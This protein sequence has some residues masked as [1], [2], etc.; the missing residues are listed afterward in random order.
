[1]L[2]PELACR[3]ERAARGIAALT[4]PADP[5]YA[6]PL[7][8]AG[9]RI[10]SAQRREGT[11]LSA[12]LA[13]AFNASERYWVLPGVHVP[14]SGAARMLA[15]A[16][17]DAWPQEMDRTPAGPGVRVD[18][19]V[20]DTTTGCAY[21]IELKRGV[22]PIGADH[23]R[24]LACSLRALELVGRATA[25]HHLGCR[26]RAIR[27]LVLS[28]YGATG[29]PWHRTLTGGDMDRFF[30]LDLSAWVESHLRFF[31]F[32]VERPVPGLTGY[33][34]NALGASGV[35]S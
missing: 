11:M 9:R 6:G 10:M 15:A 19:L 33:T 32:Q 13:A 31:R 29:T 8:L 5:G 35:A 7:A 18:L 20:F 27:P 30:E 28:Y 2:D 34:P 14:I 3:A 16:P 23:R 26:V 24:Q 21:F 1:M 4:E 17:F 25:E 22:Q 12:I